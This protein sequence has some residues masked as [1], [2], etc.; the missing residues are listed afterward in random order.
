MA[1]NILIT[2]AGGFIGSHLVNHLKDKNRVV[3]L[4]RDILP[5]LWLDEALDGVT[6]VHGDLRDLKLLTRVIGHYDVTQVYH[7]AASAQ[8]KQAHKNPVE[9]FE[10]NV[11]GTVNILEACRI[12]GSSDKKIV[13]LNTDKVYGE[14]LNATEIS[15]YESSEPYA[16]SKCC[17]GFAAQTFQKTY[18]M[19][20]KMVHSVNVFGYDPFNSRLIP[21]V[22]KDCIMGKKPVIFTNDNSIR[23]YVYIDDAINAL[24][25][26]MNST[27]L[28]N[29]IFHI[30]TGWAYNQKDVIL[31]IAKIF[32]VECEYREGNMP[33]QIQEETL[34]SIN[35]DW[36]PVW[37]FEDA[38]RGTIGL[39]NEYREDWDKGFLI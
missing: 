7:L 20:V 2:G 26:V 31:A 9:V 27:A 37:D 19:N 10:S 16:T 8:V 1:E 29:N 18:D 36:G 6:L 32:G 23:E 35:W 24:V 22:V 33:F 15:R 25:T 11:M 4:V 21:N 39:F 13:I 17:Q 28:K 3:C 14:K 30:H 12:L 38:L 5:S 34:S